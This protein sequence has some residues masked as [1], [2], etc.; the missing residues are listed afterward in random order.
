MFIS[1]KYISK[2]KYGWINYEQFIAKYLLKKQQQN[3]TNIFNLVLIKFKKTKKNKTPKTQQQ[4]PH[5]KQKVNE[6]KTYFIFLLNVKFHFF[7][8]HISILFFSPLK[9]WNTKK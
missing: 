4:K 1:P 3:C 2:N 5:N 8:N 9:T 7:F 6:N